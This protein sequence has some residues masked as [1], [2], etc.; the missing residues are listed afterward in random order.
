[1]NCYC[2]HFAISSW[3]IGRPESLIIG[4]KIFARFACNGY[5]APHIT[6]CVYAHDLWQIILSWEFTTCMMEQTFTLVK[7]WPLSMWGMVNGIL[8]LHKCLHGYILRVL[9]PW[10]I[11]FDHQWVW[12]HLNSPG[13][14]HHLADGLETCAPPYYIIFCFCKHRYE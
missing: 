12:V 10:P 8:N 11:Q 4:Q 5:Q 1:M 13:T 9:A 6:N 2:R 3:K 14:I 7:G